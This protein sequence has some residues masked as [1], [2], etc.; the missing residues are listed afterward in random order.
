MLACACLFFHRWTIVLFC[1]PIGRSVDWSF[2]VCFLRRDAF[3]LSRYNL[4]TELN[5]GRRG[6]KLV[7]VLCISAVSGLDDGLC[8]GEG[9][10]SGRVA[11]RFENRT[12]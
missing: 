6:A 7:R 3:T 1:L 9:Y 2:W 4:S 8:R 12:W 5:A 11:G 10:K